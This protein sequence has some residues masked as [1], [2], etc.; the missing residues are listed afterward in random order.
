MKV[1]Q[2]SETLL[3]FLGICSHQLHKPTNEFLKTINAY[4]CLVGFFGPLCGFSA[5]FIYKNLS[6]LK[7]S[8]NALIVLSA[9]IATAAS[10]ITIGVNMKTVKQLHNELQNVVDNCIKLVRFTK[11]AFEIA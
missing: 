8:A 7:T 3:T 11:L 4:V 5:A 10:Y 9:G 2:I 1:L 6:D